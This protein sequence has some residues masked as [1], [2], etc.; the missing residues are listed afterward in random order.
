L[1]LRAR[2]VLSAAAGERDV[3]I[4]EKLDCTRRTVGNWR[5]RFVED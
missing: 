2:I 4:A 1:V 3:Q 5:R